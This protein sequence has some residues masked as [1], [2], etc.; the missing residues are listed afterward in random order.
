[1][2]PKEIRARL[3]QLARE[4]TELRA[5]SERGELTDEQRARIDA[6]ATEA[7]D[8]R[9][10]LAAAETRQANLDGFAALA[11][12]FAEPAGVAASDRVAT[13]ERQVGEF[14]RAANG[15][16]GGA[17]G[18]AFLE[19]ETFKRYQRHPNG[20]S[21]RVAVGSPYHRD[22]GSTPLITADMSPE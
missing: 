8:L 4:G 11:R 22:L 20:K 6:L 19:S 18:R 2:T 10:Q 17:P 14:T 7:A 9:Q 15:H 13:G 16:N 3:A 1:M 12:D 5:A 21:E